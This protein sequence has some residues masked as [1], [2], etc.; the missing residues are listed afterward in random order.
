V[1]LGDALMDSGAARVAQLRDPRKVMVMLGSRAAWSEV[2]EYNPRIARPGEKGD[3]QILQ[4]RSV[5]SNMR[6]YHLSKTP[7]KWV[8]DLTFRPQVGEIY[9]SYAEQQFAGQFHPPQVVIEPNIKP[10]ASPN[11]QWPFEN[12]VRFAQMATSAG[13]KLVQLGPTGT[14]TLPGVQLIPTRSFREAC[15]VLAGAKACV[16]PEGG[17]HH[18]AAALGIPGVVIFGGFT[19]VELTGYSVHR[20]LGVSLGDACGMRLQCDHC[21]V[22]MKKITPELVLVELQK[23]LG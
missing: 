17:T 8:Y 23:V 20:N 18:A 4:G 15:A 10:G 12:W 3:F 21:A 1:G 13:L 6:P 2:W 22:E 14:R 9:L 16:L 11:K 5:A 7:Q 19:P